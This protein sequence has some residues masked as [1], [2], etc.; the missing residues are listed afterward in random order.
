MEAGIELWVKLKVVD[1]VAETA[2][3]T[4]T[5]KLDFTGRLYGLNRYFRWLILA[6]GSGQEE[7]ADELENIVRMDS[8]FIN[9]N[10]H[11]YS[12]SVGSATDEGLALRRGDFRHERDLIF[13]ES[14]P[15][16]ERLPGKPDFDLYLCDCLVTV[17]ENCPD[18]SVRLN[19]RAD[20]VR[21]M[22]VSAGQVWRLI[23]RAEDKDEASTLVNK[24]A[25]TRSRREGLLM[26]PHYQKMDLIGIE[27]IQ[28][29]GV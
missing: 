29:E 9:E 19:G 10:K 25:V 16:G 7:I 17:P 4:L 1:L 28:S 11:M 8:V 27:K 22:D 18:Y 6:S 13:R 26:N 14:S 24:I 23:L 3:Y 2:W 21:I 15:E 12:M 5:E 20:S